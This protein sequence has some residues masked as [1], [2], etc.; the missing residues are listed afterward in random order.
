MPS[1][2]YETLNYINTAD[3]HVRYIACVIILQTYIIYMHNI[4]DL[5]VCYNIADLHIHYIA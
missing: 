4:A 5:H 3:L 2:L 1:P